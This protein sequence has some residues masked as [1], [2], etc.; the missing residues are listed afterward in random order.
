MS[1]FLP[2]LWHFVPETFDP[3]LLKF[4]H[5][6]HRKWFSS[7][8]LSPFTVTH[9]TDVIGCLKLSPLLLRK[10]CVCS[11]VTWMW[12]YVYIVRAYFLWFMHTDGQIKKEME[13]CDCS[14]LY[15][16]PPLTLF[17]TGSS[18]S[19]RLPRAHTN[20]QGRQHT[21]AHTHS[22]CVNNCDDENH[23]VSV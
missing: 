20:S 11:F 9:Q 18:S 21:V 12:I 23:W 1:L 14:G 10:L 16:R 22:C 2:K 3:I 15:C 19:E 13:K 17:H 7:F 6:H 5:C 4:R 8:P